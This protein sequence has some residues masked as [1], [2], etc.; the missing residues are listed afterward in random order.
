MMTKHIEGRRKAQWARVVERV[1][2]CYEAQEV[3]FGMVYRWC[4]ECIVVECGCGERTTLTSS[5]TTCA[6]CG[7][8]HAAIVQEWLGAE[9][10]EEDEA[11]HPWRYATD[12]EEVGLPC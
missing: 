10:P 9:R 1:R 7:T 8:D 4:P 11:L 3:P 12:R 5:R 6:G 2:G